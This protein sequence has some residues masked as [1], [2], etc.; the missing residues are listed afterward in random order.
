MAL[1]MPGGMMS[2]AVGRGPPV[3]AVERRERVEGCADHVFGKM[4]GQP[5][6]K[7]HGE[8][9]EPDA[10]RIPSQP[11]HVRPSLSPR[12]AGERLES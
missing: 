10:D 12:P 3:N 5:G 1:V 2:V 9:A 4:T 6:I 7:R 8:H 11:P